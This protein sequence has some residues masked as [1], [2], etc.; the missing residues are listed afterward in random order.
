[1]RNNYGR[2]TQEAAHNNLD[3]FS[4]IWWLCSARIY[5]NS[6]F[7]R[8]RKTGK[9]QF[10]LLSQ[11]LLPTARDFHLVLHHLTHWIRRVCNFGSPFR[12]VHRIGCFCSAV[13][14]T[15]EFND[16]SESTSFYFGSFMGTHWWFTADFWCHL[17][18]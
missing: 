7:R 10:I 16:K 18:R 11:P 13:W 15:N 6:L 4:V 1:M 14:I 8:R 5:G 12:S 17:L 9:E 2:L 3:E